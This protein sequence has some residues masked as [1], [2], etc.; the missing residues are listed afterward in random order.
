MKEPFKI[1]SVRYNL[2]MNIILKISSFVFPLITFP[3]V[4]RV[5]GAEYNGKIAFGISIINYIL[6]FANLGI[7]TYGVK[8]CAQ[9]REDRDKLSKTVH[10]LFILNIICVFISYIVLALLITFIPKIKDNKEL[11]IVQSLSIILSAMGLEWFYQAIEQYDYITIRNIAFKTLSVVLMFIFVRQPSDYIKYAGV[12]VLGS[13]GSNVLN[14]LRAHKF[15]SFK[16]YSNYSFSRH[17]KPIFMLVMYSAASM[18]YANLDSVMLEF[19]SGD[20][21]VGLYSA[22]TKIKSLLVAFITSLGAVTISRISFYVKNGQKDDMFRLIRKSFEYVTLLSVPISLYCIVESKALI[23]FLA[24]ES[25]S[26][27]AGAMQWIMPCMIFIGLTS[28]TTWQIIIP[29]GKEK[30]TVYGALSG[31]IVDVIF[32]ALLIPRYGAVGASIGTILAEVAVLIT[33]FAFLRSYFMKYY[34]I[35]EAIKIFGGSIISFVFL[36]ILVKHINF[37]PV[38]EIIISGVLFFGIYGIFL[39]ITKENIVWSIVSGFLSRIK[40]KH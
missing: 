37:I 5:L 10:E 9:C 31:A 28:I 3:Y 4:S 11:M 8:I 32:N 15:I 6:M 19:I 33:H 20:Y 39:I 17:I 18:I 14:T 24:G 25:Y 36:K 40:A 26:E 1:H 38:I 23:R 16:P 29:I 12:I 30:Y 35:K 21:Q 22:A 27:A 34:P 2:I 7:P 13:Y